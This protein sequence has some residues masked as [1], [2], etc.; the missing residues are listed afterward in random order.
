MDQDLKRRTVR[1]QAV[2]ITVN[3]LL[4][5]FKLAAGLTAR[6][7][8][9][10]SSAIENA[11]DIFKDVMVFFSLR[12]SS[13]ESDRDHPY[14]HERIESLTAVL[15]AVVLALV[16]AGIGLNSIRLLASGVGGGLEPPGGLALAAKSVGSR[17]R[18]RQYMGESAGAGIRVKELMFRYVRR[19]ALAVRSDALMATAWDHRSD[20]LSSAGSFVGILGARLGLPILDPLAGLIICLFIF[21]A[22]WDIFNSAMGKLVDRSCDPQTEADIRRAVLSEEGVLALDEMRTR[23]FG[24]RIYVDIAIACDGDLTLTQSHDIAERVHERVE[25]D[26]PDVKHCMVHVNPYLPPDVS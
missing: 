11:S 21:R 17:K 25:R 24:P 19:G 1:V 12:M 7:S 6:S 26:F 3:A 4:A 8:A 23:L 2:N 22:A 18:I 9:M 14:G 16:G 10:V 15:L 13:K 5:A 20:V